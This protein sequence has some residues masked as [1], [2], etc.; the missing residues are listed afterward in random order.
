MS[1]LKRARNPLLGI[2]A[3]GAAT[4]TFAPEAKADVKFNATV[5]P[6]KNI[7]I[8]VGDGYSRTYRRRSRKYTNYG[9]GDGRYIQRRYRY[10]RHHPAGYYYH[11][12]LRYYRD[13]YGRSRLVHY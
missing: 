5:C 4:L 6:D 13:H 7:C 9:Y 3:A 1:F 2:L 10:N 8:T 11:N 12:G